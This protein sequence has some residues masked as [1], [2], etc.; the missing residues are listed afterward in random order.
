MLRPRALLRTS[1]LAGALALA[2]VLLQTLLGGQEA[3]EDERGEPL[4]RFGLL[5][6]VQY[7][8]KEDAGARRYRATLDRLAACAADLRPRSL[9]FA[10]HL[11]DLIDGR[12]TEEQSVEDLDRVLELLGGIGCE[13]HCAIGNHCLDVPRERL[14]PRLGRKRGWTSFRR[15][16]WRFA[17]LDALDV[18]LCG[19]AEDSPSYRA[20]R[21]WLAEHPLSEH[22]NAQ[23]WNG[24]LGEAQIEWLEG[25]LEAADRAGE[26][27]V[28]FSHLPIVAEASTPHHLLWNREEVLEVLGRHESVFAWFNGHD[29]AGGY[30]ERDG[31]HHLTVAGMVESSEEREA[32]AVVEVH[33]D[34]LEVSGRG[35]VPSRE[36][37]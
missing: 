15:E 1:A 7:A 22:P 27:V 9:A 29:H 16:G 10:V 24:G 35:A 23:I 3:G 2:L 25:E 37:R 33:A 20:A 13:V 26:R 6:D 4:F 31:I 17:V 36:L 19:V 11:G 14:L 18:S 8:D 5:A 28:L 34:H 21:A 12:E 32:W 30:A